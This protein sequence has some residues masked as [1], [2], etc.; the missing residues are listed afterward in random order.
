MVALVPAGLY[1]DVHERQYLIAYIPWEL[2]QATFAILYLVVV[3]AALASLIVPHLRRRYTGGLW[4][5]VLLQLIVMSRSVN[6]QGTTS[7]R[8]SA[9]AGWEEKERRAAAIAVA[10]VRRMRVWA[11]LRKAAM[12]WGRRRCARASGPPRR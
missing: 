10:P 1:A 12:I 4:T 7:R 11:R 8:P 6:S 2:Q 3:L 5:A 9:R